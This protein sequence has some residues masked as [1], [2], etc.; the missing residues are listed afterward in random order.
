VS[1]GNQH[2]FHIKTL[3]AERLETCDLGHQLNRFQNRSTT[4]VQKERWH[5]FEIPKKP[6]SMPKF[7]H[8]QPFTAQVLWRATNVM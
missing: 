5:I 7:S 1:K 6:Y 2:Q 8:G 3:T 4:A